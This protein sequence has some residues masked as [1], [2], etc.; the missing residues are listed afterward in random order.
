M[1]GLSP[2]WRKPQRYM[3][4]PL[5]LLMGATERRRDEPWP[6]AFR[7]GKWRGPRLV[8]KGQL[9]ELANPVVEYYFPKRGH[10]A[11]VFT[12]VLIE[13]VP[14][15]CHRIRLKLRLKNKWFIV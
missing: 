1:L 2:N 9:F 7:W 15:R 4:T 5:P 11:G 14:K 8:W 6:A 12:W 13:R 3:R 10:H